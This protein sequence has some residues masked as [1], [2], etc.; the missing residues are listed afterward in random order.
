MA[1][2]EGRLVQVLIEHSC[3][4]IEPIKTIAAIS[5]N[6]IDRNLVGR[7]IGLMCWYLP[8]VRPELTL[9]LNSLPRRFYDVVLETDVESW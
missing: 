3:I 4:N 9:E 5:V 2:L 8:P 6:W 1:H 7:L